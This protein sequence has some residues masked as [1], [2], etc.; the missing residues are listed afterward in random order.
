VAN[1]AF[2]TELIRATHEAPLWNDPPDSVGE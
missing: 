1:L 2:I